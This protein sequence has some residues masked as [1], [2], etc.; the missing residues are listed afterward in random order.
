[1][2]AAPPLLKI[3]GLQTQFETD[4]GIVR[5]VDGISLKIEKGHTLGLVGESGSGKSVTSLT[6]MRLLP[7]AAARIAS[8]S[9]AW[10]GKDLV[11]LSQREMCRIRGADIGMIFQEPGT[12]LNPVYKVGPQVMEAIRLHERV[13]RAEARERTLK[14]FHEVGI[15]NPEVR[16]ESRRQPATSPSRSRVA[17]CSASSAMSGGWRSCLSRT[18]SG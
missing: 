18:T 12:S 11:K 8:G 16:M 5:A 10:L 2:S 13:T 15:P 1:M 6:V 14:L 7:D 3:D 4:E 9:I 17:I